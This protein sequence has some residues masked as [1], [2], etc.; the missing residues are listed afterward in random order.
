MIEFTGQNI[1][2]AGYKPLDL[3]KEINSLGY[4]LYYIGKDSKLYPE[5]P[6]DNYKYE[7]LIAIK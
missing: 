4:R 7:N 2:N 1:I 5:I 6:K 3:I